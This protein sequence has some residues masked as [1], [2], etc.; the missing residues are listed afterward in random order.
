M[1]PDL[2]FLDTSS[3]VWYNTPMTSDEYIA[4]VD[5]LL[6]KLEDITGVEKSILKRTEEFA[7]E[8]E[9]IQRKYMALGPDYSDIVDDLD[10]LRVLV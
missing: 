10:D 7:D 3:P 2:F 8:V 6:N 1:G 5:N 9:R 4:F